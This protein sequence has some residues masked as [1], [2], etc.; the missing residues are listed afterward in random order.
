[1][2]AI[3]HMVT[4]DH[5]VPIVITVP[6]VT[7]VPIVFIAPTVIIGAIAIRG[8][9]N[10]VVCAEICTIC[11]TFFGIFKRKQTCFSGRGP[12]RT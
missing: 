7:T 6:I 10:I 8:A 11:V 12:V 5:I 2:M 9:I 1:M 4:G 3:H